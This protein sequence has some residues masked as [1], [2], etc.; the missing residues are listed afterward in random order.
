[1][2][3]SSHRVHSS[4]PSIAGGSRGSSAAGNTFPAKTH[5]HTHTVNVILDEDDLYFYNSTTIPGDGV[6]MLL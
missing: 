5:T 6:F 3:S 2:S 4:A 1:M